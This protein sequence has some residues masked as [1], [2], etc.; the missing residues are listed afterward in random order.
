MKSRILM[1]SI[2]VLFTGLGV[3]F[4]GL[5]AEKPQPS[6]ALFA[7][8][9]PAV[10]SV[11]NGSVKPL[12]VYR[13]KVVLVNFWAT[14]CAPCVQEMPELS[15][16]QTELGDKK[17]NLIGIGID[18]PDS[19]AE[20]AQKYKITYPLFVAGM[21]GTQL[22]SELGNTSGG[23]PYTVILNKSG[24]VMKTYRGRLDIAQVRKDILAI[25]E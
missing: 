11:N 25:K 4:S 22:S 20:F 8:S 3:Y 7:I 19:L 2:A 5:H 6:D 23:L 9:L 18:S 10:S 24:V 1:G 12:S 17:V 14:W 13:N 21:S 15:A 16:L